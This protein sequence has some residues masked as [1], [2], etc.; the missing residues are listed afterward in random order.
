MPYSEVGD[1][2]LGDIPK[3]SDA[4]AQKYVNDAADEIDSKL[5][6]RYQ[7][8][9]VVD[10]SPAHRATELLLKRINNWLASGRYIMAKSASSSM[11]DINTYGLQLIKDATMA[12]DAIVSG[13][14][15][16]P[17]VTFLNE[18]DLGRSGP[19][20]SNLDAESNVESFYAWTQQDP[21][22]YPWSSSRVFPAG[23]S[24]TGG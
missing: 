5:G 21:L 9:I 22:S 24:Y 18:D 13:D 20:I 11:T 8:P 7:T 10:D 16:L 19:M 15:T 23:S 1:M 12:L 6:L 4:D 3:S 17:G 2:L 14:V